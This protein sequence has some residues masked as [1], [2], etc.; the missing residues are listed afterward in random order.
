M[1]WAE[2]WAVQSNQVYTI[3]A[4][5]LFSSSNNCTTEDDVLNIV[6]SNVAFESRF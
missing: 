1:K 4:Q 6:E 3:T 5:N 2:A